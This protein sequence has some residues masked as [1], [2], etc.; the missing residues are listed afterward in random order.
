[1]DDL[2]VLGRQVRKNPLSVLFDLSDD[3][4]YKTSELIFASGKI[5]SGQIV[6]ERI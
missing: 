4:A 2:R 5:G 1:M 3:N 6:I